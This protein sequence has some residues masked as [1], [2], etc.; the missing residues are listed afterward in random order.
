MRGRRLLRVAVAAA[1]ATASV[2]A[3]PSAAGGQESAADMEV[4]IT[5][6]R[7]ADGRTEFA[8][9]Q[10]ASDGAWGERLLSARRFFPAEAPPGRWLASSPLTVAA[11]STFE[12][13]AADVEV[14]VTA[15]RLADGRIEFALQRRAPDGAWSGRLSPTQR[16][17]PATATTGDW[18]S[19]SPLT[20]A[21]A[22]GRTGPGTTAPRTD[23]FTLD[24][25]AR[26]GDTLV[27]A[28][29]SQTCAVRL[30][31][32]WTAGAGRVCGSGSVRPVW[33]MS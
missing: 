10:R 2:A 23:A 27:A 17:F 28:S 25:G 13:S 31:G 3:V 12:E 15:R 32:A 29:H 16:Y 11:S 7:L 14:R 22:G 19:S 26:S 24:R 1:A 33:T 4:R 21:V 8:L 20:L 30:D 6:R 9:Q 5:A 18:L